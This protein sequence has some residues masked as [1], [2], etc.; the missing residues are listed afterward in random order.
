VIERENACSIRRSPYDLGALWVVL[1]DHLPIIEE[2]QSRALQ[3]SIEELQAVHLELSPP[4]VLEPTCI[5]DNDVP[6]FHDYAMV[7]AIG[8]VTVAVSK[9]LA[10]TI[11]R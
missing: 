6:L 4:R 3:R 9:D 8:A 7:R 5:I 2:V 11:K 1:L 10:V